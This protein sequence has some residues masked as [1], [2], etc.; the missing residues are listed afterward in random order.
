M[1]PFVILAYYSQRDMHVAL[2]LLLPFACDKPVQEKVHP[3]RR[4][5]TMN[6]YIALFPQLQNIVLVWA[7]SCYVATRDIALSA[8]ILSMAA[9]VHGL[10]IQAPFQVPVVGSTLK[11]VLRAVRKKV[12]GSEENLPMDI[13][14]AWSRP[15][16]IPI[17]SVHVQLN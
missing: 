4:I 14:I 6:L 13:Q 7:L 15:C 8:S 1:S 12:K 9:T 2:V 11:F 5:G 16:Q 3:C 17:L 10:P